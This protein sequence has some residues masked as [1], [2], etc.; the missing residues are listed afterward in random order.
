MIKKI[1]RLLLLSLLVGCTVTKEKGEISNTKRLY[2]NVTSEYNGYFNAN[3]LI[4]KSKANLI[5]QV[6][7]DYSR[8]LPIFPYIEA[9]NASSVYADCDV[10][11][12]KM[13]RIVALHGPGYWI[14]DCYLM[15]GVAQFLKQDY[16]T[17]ETSLLYFQQEFEQGSQRKSAKI[18]RAQKAKIREVQ[19]KEREKEVKERAKEREQNVKEREKTKKQ[20]Q[21]E[22]KK[23][24]KE[25]E[26]AAKKGTSAGAAP[27]ETRRMMEEAERK[28]QEAKSKEAESK[29]RQTLDQ[30]IAQKQEEKKEEQK[31]SEK[32]EGKF[33]HRIVYDEGLLWLA[34]TYVVRKQYLT[35]Q[36]LLRRLN[37]DP[38]LDATTRLMTLKTTAFFHI[39]QEEY[40]QA[41]PFLKEAIALENKKL[42]KARLSYIV[43]QLYEKTKRYAEAQQTYAQ[44]IALKPDYDLSFSAKV[45][46]IIAGWKGSEASRAKATEELEKLSKDGKNVDYEDRIYYYIGEI[47]MQ[48]H[49][50]EKALKSYKRSV[51][52]KSPTPTYRA[53]SYR[54]LGDYF[55][56]K[57]DFLPA[58]LYYDSTLLLMNELDPEKKILE[59]RRNSIREIANAM[60]AI[61][62]QDSLIRI[63]QM[64]PE[65]QEAIAL[66]IRNKRLQEKL[67]KEKEAAAKA[68]KAGMG[69][70]RPQ[71]QAVGFAGG[72]NNAPA[73]SE[74]FAYDEKLVRKGQRDFDN[75]WGNRAL[76]DDWRRSRRSG[77]EE[78]SSEGGV[79][80]LRAMKKSIS[81][82]E[83]EKILEGVPKNEQEMKAC[84]KIIE[85][86]SFQLGKLYREK[87][88]DYPKSIA[89]LEELLEKYPETTHE[90]ESFFLLYL[91]YTEIGDYAKANYYKQQIFKKH[92]NSELAKALSSQISGEKSK[93]QRAE[94]DYDALYQAFQKGDHPKALELAKAGEK[95]Y[96]GLKVQAKFALLGAMSTGN[97]EGREAYIVELKRVVSQYKGSPEQIK[98][99]EILRL[100][101]QAS[102]S[103]EGKITAV[104]AADVFKPEDDKFH[105]AMLIWREG[106]SSFEQAKNYVSNFNS[107]YYRL[108]NLKISSITLDINTGTQLILIR[109]FTNAEKAM[110]YFNEAQKRIEEYLPNPEQGELFVITQNNYREILKKR[111]ADL[112][113]NFFTQHY[114]NR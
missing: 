63:S 38:D 67:D 17:A 57:E 86:S 18:S 53:M 40:T 37:E 102:A 48:N 15:V 1:S 109:T 27:R 20:L 69:G 31:K 103:T 23:A 19:Q 105:Y 54:K 5:E 66:E 95:T 46:A 92:K 61:Q 13:A 21:K 62:L 44:V 35:A 88:E 32:Y 98:A 68:A 113:R 41:I 85:S 16:E 100:L 89:I 45:N 108:E 60:Q 56:D 25:K 29:P 75:K 36:R 70:G 24:I 64:S 96:Q 47:E 110:K 39:E 101:G 114:L 9:P 79:S 52:A 12:E 107:K 10:I 93:E 8:L 55:Y 30:Q 14:D 34:K 91:N 51:K 111:E 4:V 49:Q 3:E 65:E 11:V 84:L 78:K 97:L 7:N 87:L 80:S 94:E 76:Q 58:K 106:N 74:F 50:E 6:P 71:A 28:K 82:A 112:Y 42:E 83:I 43:A 104:E 26:K 72:G 59:S 90:L 77:A 33:K 73:K 2:H 99:A 81:K 22:R